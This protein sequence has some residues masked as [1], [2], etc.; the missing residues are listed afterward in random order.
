M[1]EVTAYR[2]DIA[3]AGLPV[4]S[5]AP[6]SDADYEAIEAAVVETTRGRWFLAEYAR[7]NRHAETTG[8]IDALQ[9]IE[10][11]ID[12]PRHDPQLDR[13]RMSIME[14]AQAIART[15]DEIAAIK[16][17]QEV[18]GRFGEA[19]E[20]LDAIV[21]T[22]ETATDDILRAAEQIQEVAWTLRE[23][24]FEGPICDML[25][26]RATDIYTACSFQDLTGQRTRK[27]ISV[28][29]YLEARINAMIDIW[30][31]EGAS[32]QRA[33]QTSKAAESDDVPLGRKLAHGPARLGEGLVQTVVDT[34]LA[35]DDSADDEFSG[36]SI[37]DI[38][39]AEVAEFAA[40]SI[41]DAKAP[42]PEAPLDEAPE[43]APAD[44]LA[45]D[46]AE[47]L[48]AA[49]IPALNAA[50]ERAEIELAEI[51][52][53]EVELAEVIEA[54]DETVE[55]VAAEPAAEPEDVEV[56]DIE[57]IGAIADAPPV[58]AAASETAGESF[59]IDVVALAALES[60]AY[61]VEPVPH[62]ADAPSIATDLDLRISDVLAP[63]ALDELIAVD[64]PVSETDHEPGQEAADAPAKAEAPIV[65]AL[66]PAESSA[67]RLSTTDIDQLTPTERTAL[68]T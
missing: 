7:R 39:A 47:D 32:P 17:T 48:T 27:V 41:H 49:D 13:V 65:P 67:V 19:T 66:P 28:L 61:A 37:D 15:K 24:G 20:E 53:A 10:A 12:A 21:T 59:E 36:L 1:P 52:L 46:L 51:E 38:M 62:A 11:K 3:M 34:M 22:T 5:P 31:V 56:V 42:A 45:D 23:R 18:E 14:M 55:P 25:D 58:E 30:G 6:I 4:P 16:P 60:P 40:V 43:H 29:R 63:D 50:D 54:A 44:D 33:E 57:A 64:V 9:R 68:F 2:R 26:E 8:L 35:P